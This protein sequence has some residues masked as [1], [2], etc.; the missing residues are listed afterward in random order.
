MDGHH[1]DSVGVQNSAYRSTRP[2][3]FR[4]VFILCCFPMSSTGDGKNFQKTSGFAKQETGVSTLVDVSFKAKAKGKG[5]VQC[6]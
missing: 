6:P 4:G 2:S 5:Q 3:V 1:P